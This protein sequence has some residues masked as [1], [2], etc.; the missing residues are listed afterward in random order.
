M[1]S[2]I[3]RAFAA[4][5]AHVLCADLDPARAQAT[6]AAAGGRAQPKVLDVTDA[7]SVRRLVDEATD[8][9]GSID[10]LINNAG[11]FRAIGAAWELD[12]ALWWNDVSTNLLGP[13]LCCNAVL[14]HMIDRGS[15]VVVNISGGGFGSAVP[16]GSAYTSSKA[17]LIRMTQTI[18]LEVGSRESAHGIRGEGH[19]IRVYG[20]EPAF[21]A[22]SMNTTV[23]NSAGGRRWLPFVGAAL[24]AGEVH[25]TDPVGAA[26]R[27]LVELAPPELD[28]LTFGY[29]QDVADLA[30]RADELRARGLC[31]IAYRGP[32]AV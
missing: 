27:R 18:A 7:G 28:G 11:V 12:P 19:N 1:G 13:F 16:G 4:A 24:E 8:A 31:Q 9:F 5:G 21:V 17:A 15:G 2:A 30:T 6:A 26:I 20:V 25:P 3:V 14:P 23:A 29:D 32:D 22:G 10:V